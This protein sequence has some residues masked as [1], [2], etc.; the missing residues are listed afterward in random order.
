MFYTCFNTQNRIFFLFSFFG[1]FCGR[2]ID[3]IHTKAVSLTKN[4]GVG[5]TR[6]GYGIG[7]QHC[8]RHQQLHLGPS[9]DRPSLRNPSL[10]HLPDRIHSAQ[11]LH[12]HPSVRHQG[13]GFPGLGIRESFHY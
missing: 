3:I 2:L 7:K 11:N 4:R 1:S 8:G 13:P 12:R 5:E 9:H 10:S 6:Y